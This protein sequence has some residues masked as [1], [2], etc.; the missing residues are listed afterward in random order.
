VLKVLVLLAA[1]P[2]TKTERPR[3][4][5]LDIAP[6]EPAVAPL[7]ASLSTAVASEVSARGYFEVL[8]TRDIGAML[9]LERQKELM[10]C[11]EDSGTCNAEL[12]GALGTRLVLTGS[13]SRFG[14]AYQLTL[15]LVDNDKRQVVHRATRLAQNADVLRLQVVYA[16][17][18]ATGAPLPPPPSK[19]LP[20]GLIGGGGA[21]LLGGAVL[22]ILTLT[23]E[24]T[25]NAELEQGRMFPQVLKSYDY[26]QQQAQR[27]SLFRTL[28][29]VGLCA[30]AV[31][32]TLGIVLWPP[33][34][35]GA[36]TLKVALYTQGNGGGIAGVF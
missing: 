12:A 33:D 28:S 10:G 19:V 14:D 30:G 20:Y 13:I 23:T 18:E 6:A 15:Q 34:V 26:Y 1:V 9:G 22:G 36:S 3:I 2:F 7:A 5:V 21:L 35:L 17:A 4:L 32:V 31:A 11:S 24:S 25:T 8:S 16:V 27:S 29:L